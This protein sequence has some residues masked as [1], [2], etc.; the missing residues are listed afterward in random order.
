VYLIFDPFF[1]IE[2]KYVYENTNKY[3]KIFIHNLNCII[4]IIYNYNHLFTY[5]LIIVIK[6]KL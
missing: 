4:L 5:H 2:Y 3:F 6:K 1:L